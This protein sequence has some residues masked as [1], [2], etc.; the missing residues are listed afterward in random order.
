MGTG[1]PRRDLGL[2]DPLPLQHQQLLLLECMDSR[3]LQ[4]RKNSRKNPPLFNW[5]FVFISRQT[6][7]PLGPPRIPRKGAGA[8]RSAA[9]AAPPFAAAAAQAATAAPAA[10]TAAGTATECDIIKN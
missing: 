2:R 8:R 10:A 4:R 1:P 5:G 9:D 3:R 6:G 7:G